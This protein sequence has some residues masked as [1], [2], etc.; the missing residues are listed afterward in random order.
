MTTITKA[1]I[2][3]YIKQNP[4]CRRRDMPGWRRNLPLIL[5]ALE[6]LEADGVLEERLFSDPANMEYY[7]QYYIKEA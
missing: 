6:D 1:F 5:A 4:G 3:N 7:Y 2:Y